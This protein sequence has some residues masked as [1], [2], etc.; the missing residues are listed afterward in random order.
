MNESMFEQ[1]VYNIKYTKSLKKRKI[2]DVNFGN[3]ANLSTMVQNH[4]LYL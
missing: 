4:L 2:E 1:K 3:I